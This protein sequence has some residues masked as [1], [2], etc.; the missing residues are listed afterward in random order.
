MNRWR[1]AELG[2]LLTLAARQ[3][4]GAGIG[5]K[6]YLAAFGYRGGSTELKG[7]W[8]HLIE[9]VSARG[10]LAAATGQLLEHYLR[11][12]TLAARIGKAVGLLPTRAKLMKVYE[13][14]CEALADSRPFAPPP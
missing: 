11:H 3:G 10:S 14:L 1:T 6:R 8:E 9:T 12:G 2:K 5:D 7:L 13:E 4:E